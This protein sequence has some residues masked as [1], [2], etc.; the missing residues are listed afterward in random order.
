MQQ[1]QVGKVAAVAVASAADA[2]VVHALLARAV[3]LTKR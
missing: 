2:P 1:R 3:S